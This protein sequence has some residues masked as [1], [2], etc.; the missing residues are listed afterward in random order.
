M[1]VITIVSGQAGGLSVVCSP[2]TTKKNY[3]AA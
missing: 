2:N 1:Q 3:Q